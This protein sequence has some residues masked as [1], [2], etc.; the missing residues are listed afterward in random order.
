MWIDKTK[1]INGTESGT[2]NWIN[3]SNILNTKTLIRGVAKNFFEGGQSNQKM[4][5]TM[6]G[7]QRKFSLTLTC[8]F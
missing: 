8:M 5:A 7:R 2:K 3:Q 4:S 1:M 6:V